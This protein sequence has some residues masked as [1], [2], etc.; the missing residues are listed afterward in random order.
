MFEALVPFL[1]QISAHCRKEERQEFLRTLTGIAALGVHSGFVLHDR[2]DESQV[3]LLE[4]GK[5]KRE[6]RDNK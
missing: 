4:D 1:M 3:G 2:N 5:E 6:R